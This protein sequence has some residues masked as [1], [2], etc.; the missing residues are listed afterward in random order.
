MSNNENILL[1]DF[2][3]THARF[4]KYES[5]G[6]YSDFKKYRLNDFESFE[7][8]IAI[9]MDDCGHNFTGARFAS[10]RAAIDGVIHYRRHAGDPIYQI[11]FNKIKDDFNWGDLIILNDLTAGAHGLPLLKPDDS[12]IILNN[13]EPPWNNFHSLISVGTGI[14]YSGNINGQILETPGGHWLPITVTE[15]HRKIEKFIRRKK[16]ENF[17]LIMEDFI[18]GHGLR[19]IAGYTSAFPNDDM[20]PTEFMQDLKHNPDAIRLFFEFLGIYAN[21]V[22][23]ITGFYGGLFLT[24]GVIDNLVKNDLTNWDAFE[25]YFR[26]KMV[27]SVNHRLNGT[28]VSY[29]L[30]DELPLLGL[31]SL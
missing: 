20:S 6:Q 16:D 30:N 18:S 12:K 14:G 4:A 27:Q 5:K 3:G 23:A 28:S 31:T 26:P 10:A 24:G 8:I 15:E 25:S 17:A 2:G 1:C 22:T 21:T 19:A 9:Y 11:N 29:I 7:D 13:D